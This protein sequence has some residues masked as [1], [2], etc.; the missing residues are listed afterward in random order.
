[1][2]TILTDLENGVA[3]LV[4]DLPEELTDLT[5]APEEI[6]SAVDKVA[7]SLGLDPAKVNDTG[8][9]VLFHLFDIV[10]G[11]ITEA[12]TGH[13]G[14]GATTDQVPPASPAEAAPGTSEKPLETAPPSTEREPAA[15]ASPP[16]APLDTAPVEHGPAD[17]DLPPV[18]EADTGYV[19]CPECNGFRTVIEGGIVKVCPRC[20]GAGQILA[21]SAA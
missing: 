21:T 5:G 15:P 8:K 13:A 1:M 11:A 19:I 9:S 2:S 3:V 10:S 12:A 14:A 18:T 16:V 7:S 20:K 4:H 17:V 6:L